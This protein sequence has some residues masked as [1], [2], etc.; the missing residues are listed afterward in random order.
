MS[1]AC[2]DRRIQSDGSLMRG[3]GILKQAAIAQYLHKPGQRFRI[4]STPRQSPCQPDHRLRSTPQ[5][6]LQVGIKMVSAGQIRI[7]HKGALKSHF[8]Y[9]RNAGLAVEFVQQPAGAPQPSHQ[10]TTNQNRGK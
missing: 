1:D 8:C 9:V 2:L 7:D 4:F 3:N 10:L 5:I 6:N